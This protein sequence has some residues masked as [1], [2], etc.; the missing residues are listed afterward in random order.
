MSDDSILVFISFW[1]GFALGLVTMLS[2]CIWYSYHKDSER[3][4]NMREI[5]R[6]AEERGYRAGKEANP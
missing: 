2:I 1:L 4:D 6:V 5:V 3:I